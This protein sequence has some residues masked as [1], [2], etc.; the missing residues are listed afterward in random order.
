VWIY[1]VPAV[2]DVDLTLGAEIPFVD[3]SAGTF[4]RI[5]NTPASRLPTPGSS[6]QNPF[7]ADDNREATISDDG[8]ILAFVSTR[9]LV[10]AVGNADGN[11]EI[12]FFNRGTSTFTQ[13]TT[14]Q[15]LIV[16]GLLKS[17]VFNSNPSISA[18]GSKFAFISN[19]NYTGGNDDGG[20]G[21]GNAE[22]FV[23][24]YNGATVSNFF[25]VTRTKVDTGLANVNV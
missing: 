17:S 8:N 21:K 3:L 12:F 19:A 1:Q 9:N 25:Q 11:P 7:I 2:A 13:A 23:G 18:D 14:S 6:T 15:D 4:T 5:T 10:P 24:T 20:A 16:G 22:I